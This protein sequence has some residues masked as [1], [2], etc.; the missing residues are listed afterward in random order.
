M[1]STF[2]V[3]T[4]IAAL[5][6]LTLNIIQFVI[7]RKA[8]SLHTADMDGIYTTAYRAI[9]E[10][11]LAIENI[12]NEKGPMPFIYSAKSTVNAIREKCQE[13]IYQF[14]KRLPLRCKPWDSSSIKDQT[15]KPMKQI[16]SNSITQD[17]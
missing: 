11:D 7:S 4:G 12:D 13:R 1:I 5:I 3:I 9:E 8:K 2:A 6:S 17:N 14:E 15:K 10:L 16:A